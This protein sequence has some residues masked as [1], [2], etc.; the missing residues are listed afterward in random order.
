[1]KIFLILKNKQ[2]IFSH[3]SNFVNQLQVNF[4]QEFNIANLKK[5]SR[6]LRKFV[7]YA[8]SL[9]KVAGNCN[10]EELFVSTYVHF[11]YSLKRKNH[12]VEFCKLSDEHY[13]KTIKFCSVHWLGTKTGSK[14]G[15]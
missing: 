3:Y 2:K 11:D 15:H 12:F 6:N 8:I 4:L 14:T 9:L 10:A 7:S 5:N 13:C 1:M